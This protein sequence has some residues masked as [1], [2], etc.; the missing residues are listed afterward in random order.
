MCVHAFQDSVGGN[1]AVKSSSL[2]V[3]SW[4]TTSGEALKDFKTTKAPKDVSAALKLYIS[5]NPT[6]KVGTP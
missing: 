3:L 4:Q 2:F 6:V 5:E 1:P